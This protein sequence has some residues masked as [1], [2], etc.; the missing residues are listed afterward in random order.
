[1]TVSNQTVRQIASVMGVALVIALIG[2]PGPADALDA[3]DRVY[4]LMVAAAVV[5]A[6]ISLTINTA[7]RSISGVLP[8]APEVEPLTG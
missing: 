6:V 7:P 2:S 5:T 1:V 4:E 8:V 3:F